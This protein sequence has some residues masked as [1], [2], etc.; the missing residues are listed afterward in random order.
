MNRRPFL[1][2]L[3]AFVALVALVALAHVDQTVKLGNPDYLALLLRLDGSHLPGSVRRAVHPGH[4]GGRQH[5][6]ACAARRQPLNRG[7]LAQLARKVFTAK[8]FRFD[9]GDLVNYGILRAQEKN[10]RG[11]VLRDQDLEQRKQR[12]P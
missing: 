10:E 7:E 3:F 5:H 12:S 4:A 1:A 9:L 11:R 8:Q 6:P 2:G